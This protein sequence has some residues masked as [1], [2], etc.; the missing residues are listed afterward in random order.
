MEKNQKKRYIVFA[1]N[2]ILSLLAVILLNTVAS[3]CPRGMKCIRTTRIC[4]IIFIFTCL[5]NLTV[6]IFHKKQIIG[7]IVLM[8]QALLSVSHALVIKT[9]GMCRA[10]DMKCNIATTPTI[11]IIASILFGISLVI[12]IYDAAKNISDYKKSKTSES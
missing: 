8:I 4:E 11:G 6:I 7:K 1:I 10:K 9:S 3:P 5:A 12:I 2:I